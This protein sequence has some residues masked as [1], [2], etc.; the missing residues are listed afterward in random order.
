MSRTILITGANGHLGRE[1]LPILHSDGHS[2]IAVTGSKAIP[3]GLEKEAVKLER[4]N[5]FEEAETNAFIRKTIEEN[6][7]LDA[8]VLLA[9]GYAPGSMEETDEASIDQQITLNFKTAWFV[10]KPV[11]EHFKQR[12]EGQFIF[13]GARPAILPE[14]GKHNVAYALSKSLLLSL[15]EIINAE[16]KPYGITASVIILST[17]DTYANRKEMPGADY[18]NW[19][20]PADVADTI[21]FVLS[22]AGKKLR[23]PVYK[24]FNKA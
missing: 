21:R 20:P 16:G 23:Q 6:P 13:I 17:L 7:D 10:V 14:A 5:L 18:A 19:V 3:E 11:L 15:A 2:I 1:V 8:A 22:D 12:K 9:G 24:L 4:V